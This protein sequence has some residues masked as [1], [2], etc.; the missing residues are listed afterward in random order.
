MSKFWNQKQDMEIY[1]H[2]RFLGGCLAG[3]AGLRRV[4]SGRG[5]RLLEVLSVTLF[6]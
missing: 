4:M 6:T 3:T 2:R 5:K 1:A